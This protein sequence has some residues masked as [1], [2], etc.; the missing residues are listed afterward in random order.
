[1]QYADQQIISFT[2]DPTN[3]VVEFTAT[4]GKTP[5]TWTVELIGWA[6][7]SQTFDAQGGART[8]LG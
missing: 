7:V 6:V 4:G 1:M 3:R 8:S 5:D 2:L